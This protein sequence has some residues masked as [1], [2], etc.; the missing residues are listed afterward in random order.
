MEERDEA[1]CD[2]EIVKASYRFLS[3]NPS[4]FLNLWQWSVFLDSYWQTGCEKQKYYCCKIIAIVTNANQTKLMSLM[5]ASNISIETLLFEE[6]K[7]EDIQLVANEYSD[8]NDEETIIKI[9]NDDYIYIEGVFLP[10]FK[11]NTK[12]NYDTTND[13]YLVP[14][15][16]ANLRSLALAVAANKPVCLTGPVGCGKTM[17]VEYL[18]RKTR[19]LIEFDTVESVEESFSVSDNT[20][21]DKS[22]RKREVKQNKNEANTS[23]HGNEVDSEDKDV[24]KSSFLRIQLGDQTDSK[25]LLGQYRC[26]DVP[27]EFVW[28]PGVLTQA[29][30]NG[31]WILLEDLNSAT[32]D[33]CTVL[34]SLLENNFLTV[35][36]FRDNLKVA[37]GFQLF[38]TLR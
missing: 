25:T 34:T 31:Y 3:S 27:G 10:I 18:A 36:G 15:T 19:R 22:K 37:P 30:M 29:V 33:V 17:L 5:K 35:P 16:H 24:Q 23:R 12:T 6:E 28:Q 2:L 13:P 38:L 26:T 1:V 7:T 14:S 8:A 32:Q 9:D 4:L 21:E 11:K 20:D